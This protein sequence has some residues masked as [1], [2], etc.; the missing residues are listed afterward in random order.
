MK[1]MFVPAFAIIA[2]AGSA[3]AFTAKYLE[4]G[5]VYCVSTIVTQPSS[6][7]SC[8]SQIPGDA[9]NYNFSTQSGSST[10][11]C[12][13]GDNTYIDDGS[14]CNVPG[15]NVLFQQTANE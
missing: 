15:G 12:P 2:I 10:S 7:S 14:H 4:P 1:K 11:P 3:L 6:S 13:S 8:L 5:D 9:V